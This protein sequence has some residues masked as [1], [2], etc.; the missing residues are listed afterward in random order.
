MI[1]VS[2]L[3][4]SFG[5]RILFKD[6]NIQFNKGYCYGLI[7]AN[8]SGKSTFLK[9]LS[10]EVEPTGGQVTI[11]KKERMAVLKQDHFAFDEY[12]VIETVIMGHK[13]LYDI[14]KERDALYLK[15]DFTDADGER[16]SELESLMSELNGYD[17]EAAAAG[18]LSR[19]GIGEDHQN[20]LMKELEGGLKVRVLLAQA[21]F[22]SP[23]ILLMDEPTNH[24]DLN[25]IDWLEEFLLN[26]PNLVIVVSHDRHFL[27][28]VCT[29]IVDIDFKRIQ[30]FTGNYDFWY[31]ASQLVLKQKKDINKKNEEK[32]KELQSFIQRFSANASKSKQAT[33]R[34]KLL[35]NLTP[36]EMP[37]TSRQFPYIAFKPD[38]ECGNVILEV[39]GLNKSFEDEYL[40][41]EFNLVINKNDK[42]AFVG[43]EHFA[44]T[45]FF[46]IITGTGKAD[47]GKFRWGQTI[48]TSYFSKENSEFFEHDISLIDWLRAYSDEKSDSYV[49]G[50]LGRMLFSGD[51]AFKSVKV[52]SGGERVRCLLSK[53]MLSSANVLILDEPTNH[54]DLES[55][56]ALNDALINFKGVLLFNSHDHEFVQTIANR[57]IEFTPGG[58]IDRIMP[59]DE[60]MQDANIKKI[61][62]QLYHRHLELTI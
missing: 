20:L 39:E 42:I 34:K 37:A 28:R 50:F 41:R 33:S 27:N 22:G 21:L 6:V 52:L 54:L 55:I 38:R 59:F 17:A 9:I 7:G 23:D 43:T 45:A 51:E 40:I 35:D 19:L 1:N 60:Y 47:S 46:E 2:E 62:D 10:G 24:L 15:T 14:I 8:G 61:R 25:T 32:I 53:M 48:S 58:V 13:Y 12:T 44:K 11:S 30:V 36:V 4:L 26:F 3:T 49:R 56:S 31:H 5:E 57:V 16:S 18:L 29:N